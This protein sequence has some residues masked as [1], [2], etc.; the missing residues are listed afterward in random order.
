M[1]REMY[2]KIRMLLMYQLRVKREKGNNNN[3][4]YVSALCWE[5]IF[6]LLCKIIEVKLFVKKKINEQF[7]N[8]DTDSEC[9]TSNL[10]RI[11]R[12]NGRLFIINRKFRKEMPNTNLKKKIKN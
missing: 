10:P 2:H 11:Q 9:K 3:N 5:Y 6:Y 1:N 12:L 8:L 7:R 4:V